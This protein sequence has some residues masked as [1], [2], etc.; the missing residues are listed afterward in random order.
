MIFQADLLFYTAL[1]AGLIDIRK[2]KFLIDD[3]YSNLLTDPLL[4]SLYGQKEIENFRAF[5]DK[6]I[7]VYTEHRFPDQAKFPCIVIKLGGGQEDAPKDALGDSYQ[8]EN[9]DAGSL[10]GLFPS[11]RILAGPI[12]PIEYDSMTG[13]VT[14]GD[15]VNLTISNVFEGQY[16]YDEV[17]QQSYQIALVID[18]SNLLLEP[19]SKPNLTGIT[20][21]PSQNQVGHTVR[22]IWAWET[23]TLT[24]LATTANEVLYLWTLVMYIL[25]RYKKT[26]FDARNFAVST[27]TYSE[28]YR[29]SPDGD[30]N[31]LFGRDVSVRGRV[32][33]SVIESTSQLIDGL[34]LE[35]DIAD[36][37]S[38]AGVLPVVERQGWKGEGDPEDSD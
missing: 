8:Q 1:K 9:V 12:T 36:M 15:D 6:K 38:P 28:I 23:H 18:D 14:F 27:V 3:A 30:P 31:N 10:G 21:R 2:N 29:A 25:G 33:H 13:Q 35:L 34:S 16:V 4:A 19:G 24:M 32:E 37:I 17:N 20:I 5:L 22:S 11:P 26:L 7:D